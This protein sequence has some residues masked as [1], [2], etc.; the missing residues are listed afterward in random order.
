[1]NSYP[2]KERVIQAS[3]SLFNTKGYNGTSIREIATS[4][5]VNV[6]IISYYFENKKGLM[7]YLFSCFLDQYLNVIED[8]IFDGNKKSAKE[9]LHNMTNALLQFHNENK[10]LARFVYREMTLD[11]MLIREVMSTYLTKEKYY[12]NQIFDR[13]MRS[14]EFRRLSIPSVITQ[15]KGMLIM[16]YLHPQYL[17]EVLHVIPYES[18]FFKQ[19]EKEIANW[20]DYSICMVHSQSP[21]VTAQV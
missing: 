19:Y 17:T 12:L 1:M 2:S 9:M 15:Y 3:I 8:V 7:E 16:P 10:D 4:A 5:K 20:I 13:G 18:Y 21:Q 14:K 6:A 11:N